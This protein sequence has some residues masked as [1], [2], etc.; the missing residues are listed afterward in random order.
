MP[1]PSV[2][3]VYVVD[4]EQIIALTLGAILRNSGFSAF[5]F[6]SPLDALRSAESQP[7]TLLISDV[8][9][10]E[11]TGIELAIRLR[12][13]Y[14]TCKVLLFSGLAATA[15]LLESARREGHDFV[16]LAKPIHPNDLLA[17]IKLLHA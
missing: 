5:A 10:P 2:S 17:A 4:D 11:L 12:S 3:T 8:M 9:M 15:D 1:E 16:L 6:T 7:P 13:K 14:P